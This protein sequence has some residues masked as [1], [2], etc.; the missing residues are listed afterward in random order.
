MA[1][2]PP[3]PSGDDRGHV[4]LVCLHQQVSVGD[5]PWPE[6]PEDLHETCCVEGGQRGYVV[7]RHAPTLRP[8]EKGG[9]H[10][11]LVDSELRFR[12]VLVRLSDCLHAHEHIT[13]FVQSVLHVLAEVKVSALVSSHCPIVTHDGDGMP[14]VITSVFFWLIFS[15]TC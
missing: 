2:P 11:A 10:A 3:A 7:L 5:C 4:L 12:A 15:P 9:Q 14:T 13:G 8:L 1:K 6:D